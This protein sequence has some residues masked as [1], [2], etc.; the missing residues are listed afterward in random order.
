MGK[1]IVICSDGT[2]NTFDG[3]ITNVTRLVRHLALDRP[4]RQVANG[5]ART[6]QVFG[7]LTRH[8]VGGCYG[9]YLI[10]RTAA[11]DALH[12]NRGWRHA[13]APRSEGV[14]LACREGHEQPPESP[15]K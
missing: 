9:R 13:A 2:G 1:N 10:R 3:R 8:A 5:G 14:A 11:P 15:D 12:R 7:R 4:D 6:G